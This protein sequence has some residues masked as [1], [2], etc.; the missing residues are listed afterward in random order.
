MYIG[1][2]SYNGYSGPASI[3]KKGQCTL[4]MDGRTQNATN[5]FYLRDEP[6]L[7]DWIHS[8]YGMK[9]ADAVKFNNI[10]IGR[11]QFENGNFYLGKIRNGF[12]YYDIG[13]KESKAGEY[14]TLVF[15]PLRRM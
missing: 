14:E 11:I 7:F 5:C 12:L 8:Y 1:G 6:I 2:G 10:K 4:F 9:I 13:D 3:N 15:K